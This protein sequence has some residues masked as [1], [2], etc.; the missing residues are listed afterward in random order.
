VL[1]DL[2]HDLIHGAGGGGVGDNLALLR[3]ADL[4]EGGRPGMPSAPILPLTS[5][6][7]VTVSALRMWALG[8]MTLVEYCAMEMG[9]GNN[10]AFVVAPRRLI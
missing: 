3:L 4:V 5:G 10:V 2:A 7:P 1:G 8:S 9:P 6:A